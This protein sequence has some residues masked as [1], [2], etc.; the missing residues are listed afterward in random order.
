ML[1]EWRWNYFHLLFEKKGGA[2]AFSIDENIHAAK[3]VVSI[4]M[5]FF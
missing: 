4:L 3:I 1:M 5:L 2:G